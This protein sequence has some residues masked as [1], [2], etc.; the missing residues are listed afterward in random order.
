MTFEADLAAVVYFRRYHMLV[1]QMTH[2]NAGATIDETLCQAF[3]QRVTQAILDVPGLFAPMGR[4]FKPIPAV[5]DVGPGTDLA[6]PVA[7]R[8]DVTGHI[9]AEPYLLG[10]PVGIDTAMAPQV[11]IDPGDDLAMLGRRDI[12]IIGHATTAPEQF[13]RLPAP[14]ERRRLVARQELQR[15]LVGCNGHARQLLA[16]GRAV[17]AGGQVLDRGEIEIGIAPLQHPHRLEIMALEL[18]DQVLV[19]LGGIAGHPEGAVDHVSARPARDLAEFGG[20]Q[21]PGLVAVELAVVG[22]RHVPDVEIEPH[23]DGV[24]GDE[25]VHVAV[26]VHVDLGIAGAGRERPHHHGGAA[27]LAPD[28]FG[29]GVDLAGREGDDGGA[30]GLARDLFR[31]RIVKLRKARPVDD[32]GLGQQRPDHRHHGG[33]AQQQGF[34]N[35]AGP[36]HAVGEDMAAVEIGRHLDLVDGNALDRHVERH[37][38]DRAHPVARLGRDDALLAG[39]QSHGMAADAVGDLVVDL[40]GQEPQ[41]QPDH[42]RAVRQH[43]L[44]GKEGLAGV[45]GAEDRLERPGGG[46]RHSRQCRVN[47]RRL[48]VSRRDTF[49]ASACRSR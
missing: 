1:S 47:P 37:G 42:A 3:V 44:D 19:E 16:V 25:K 26:L 9:V 32:F 5:G 46:E 31:A 43:A 11:D 36:Q 10:N 7:E 48:R 27:A 41:R 45:G 24:G 23:A 14:G 40:A 15:A 28:Q 17:K 12:A 18:A 49:Y 30:L 35:A 4:V 8:V 21:R 38:F 22:E 20:T 34:G 33:S 39:H 6:D 13:H 29:N 2:E